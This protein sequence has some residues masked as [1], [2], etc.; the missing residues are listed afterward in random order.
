MHTSNDIVVDLVVDDDDN[1]GEIDERHGIDTIFVV[2]IDTFTSFGAS[3]QRMRLRSS[4]H[5]SKQY[6]YIRGVWYRLN[7]TQSGPISV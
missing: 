6:N 1:I 5:S 3:N 2:Q 4:C 7:Y